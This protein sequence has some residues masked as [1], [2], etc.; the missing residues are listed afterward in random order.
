MSGALYLKAVVSKGQTIVHETPQLSPRQRL[1][2]LLANLL[3]G[4]IRHFEHMT[5]GDGVVAG[6]AIFWRVMDTGEPLYS[7]DRDVVFCGTVK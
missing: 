7:M 1:P 5:Y 2:D 3:H 6:V 4:C